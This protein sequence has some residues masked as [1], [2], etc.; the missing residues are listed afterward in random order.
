M[1]LIHPVCQAL[2]AHP[3]AHGGFSSQ[4]EDNSVD[5]VRTDITYFKPTTGSIDRAFAVIEYKRRTV[6]KSAELTNAVKAYDPAALTAAAD[7]ARIRASIPAVQAGQLHASFFIGD[8]HRLLKQASAYAIQHRTRYV[9]LFDYDHLVC[10]YFPEL[11]H[12]ANL[13][14]IMGKATEKYVEIDVYPF[15]ESN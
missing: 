2:N 13:V 3:L 8:S 12:T 11:D 1:Y 4:C 14:T 10:L 6:V 5:G 7:L 9:A 15:T